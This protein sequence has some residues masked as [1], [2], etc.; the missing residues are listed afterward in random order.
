LLGVGGDGADRNAMGKGKI[1]KKGGDGMRPK[2]C[3]Y[4]TPTRNGKW[5]Q[6]EI[7]RRLFYRWRG[8]M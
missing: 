5:G 2:S 6:R 1:E 7:R 3:A 8:K 4:T